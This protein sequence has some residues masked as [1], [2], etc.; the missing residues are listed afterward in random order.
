VSLRCQNWVYEHSEAT[1]NE[2]LV[3]LAIADE[4]DDDGTN[5]HP[6]I[7]RIAH[8]ARVNTR[9]TMRCIERL[10]AAGR[11]IVHRPAIK[12]RGHF[13]T[14]VVLMAEGT[15]GDTLTEPERVQKG[16]TNPRNTAPAYL[17]GHR[18][19]DPGT[20][21][22]EVKD[23]P[24]DAVFATWLASTKKTARTVLDAKRR[25]LI[26]N[27]L[28]T[29]PLGDVLDAVRG[30]ENSPYHR[31]Q[32]ADRR[33]YNDLGLLL[34][35]AEHIERFRDLSRAPRPNGSDR[36]VPRGPAPIDDDRAGPS[37]LIRPEDL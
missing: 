29:H 18:P 8:K 19:I 34:R 11:L 25:T 16:D 30:W 3:L 1:G 24:V 2:R 35:D 20:Q 26:T 7:E 32:N 33:V 17:D 28:K 21:D 12:G 5:G 36:G 4:A 9:T 22:P 23:S 37:R 10:E 14:Y 13:N 6:G 31:G 27:A 15:K